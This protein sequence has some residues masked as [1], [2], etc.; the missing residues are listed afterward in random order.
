MQPRR[1]R[2]ENGLRQAVSHSSARCPPV[3]ENRPKLAGKRGLTQA[4]SVQKRPYLQ[5]IARGKGWVV[6]CVSAHRKFISKT[7]G[8]H[9]SISVV[10]AQ[11]HVPNGAVFRGISMPSDRNA[12]GRTG[13]P[14]SSP[15]PLCTNSALHHEFRGIEDRLEYDLG[16]QIAIAVSGEVVLT[17]LAPALGTAHVEVEV[18]VW[19]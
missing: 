4:Q 17:R 7:H 11:R 13:T 19:V 15:R 16:P 2:L 9:L 3:R 8:L 6:L 14:L 18:R 5:A 1:R 12:V 10:P